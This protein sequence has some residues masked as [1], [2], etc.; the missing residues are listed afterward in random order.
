MILVNTESIPGKRIVS[1]C[2]LVQGSTVR[3][4]NIGR[5]IAASIK[6][7]IGVCFKK[8]KV[9]GK[10]IKNLADGKDTAVK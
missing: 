10:K 2:G 7:I 3:A 1:V 8:M 5:D 6:N 9:I 4:K